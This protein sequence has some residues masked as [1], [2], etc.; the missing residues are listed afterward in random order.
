[1]LGGD[2]TVA[3]EVG[4][5]SVFSLWLPWEGGEVSPAGNSGSG[6]RRNER[7]GVGGS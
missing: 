3:S 4:A 7:G 5:G 6:L 2:I 1:L